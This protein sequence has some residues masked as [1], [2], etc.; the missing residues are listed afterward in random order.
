MISGP[1]LAL[2]LLGLAFLACESSGESAS[3][4]AAGIAG[5]KAVGGAGSGGSGAGG[6]AGG[7]FPEGGSG[8]RAG[9]DAGSGGEGEMAGSDSA[10]TGGKAGTGGEPASGGTGGSDG[11]ASGNNTGQGG[12]APCTTRITYG[13]SWIHGPDHPAQFD[14]ASGVVTWDGSFEIDSTGNSSVALSNGWKPYFEGKNGSILGLDASSSCKVSPPTCATRIT[15]GS[16]WIHGPDHP[17][18]FDDAGG[19]VSWDGV[20]HADGTQSYAVL[21]NGWKPY[22]EGK[23][24]CQLAFRHTQCGGLFTNP[25]LDTDCPDPGVLR[26]DG[27]YYMV[28][29]SGGPGYPIRSSP[30]L[31]HWTFQG[32]VFN[33][34]TKPSWAQGDFWAPEI[35]RVGSSFVVYFSARHKNGHFAVGAA[36][37]SS[38]LGPYQDIGHPIAE[39]PN[40]GVIDAHQ[41]E[42]STGQRYLLWKVDGN[43]VGASTPIKIQPLAADG[44]SLTGAPTTILSNTL[45]WEGALVEGPWMVEHEGQFYLFYSANGYASPS[46]AVGVAR[47]SSPTGPFTKAN[48]PIL[49]SKGAWA[50]PGHG[51]VVLGPSGDWVHVFHSWEAAHVGNA[52]GRLVLVDR[53][54][55]ADGWPLMR[56]APS[57]RSQPLP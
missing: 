50:G 6:G 36:H 5:N 37:A 19:A 28:C 14:D 51:S 48:A 24:G 55:W 21:S 2:L 1:R 34:Q 20:C 33:E 57:S 16:S 47:A 17:A 53:I 3:K 46:Y 42:T 27:A 52:P 45:G 4:D 32:T 31:V 29:T 38:V 41:F 26:V 44:L 15:Y 43:A 22:F 13:S 54:Q 12:G 56:A 18:Q 7:S 49:V 10:G 25:V 39:D 11:G 35:H 9:G 8:G 23:N 30:D 40:P